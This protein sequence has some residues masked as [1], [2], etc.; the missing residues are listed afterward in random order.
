MKLA[1]AQKDAS[2]RSRRTLSVNR[3]TLRAEVLVCLYGPIEE[4]FLI[5]FGMTAIG[6]DGC[7]VNV[8]LWGAN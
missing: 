8:S 6:V 4:R 7:Y 3:G 2:F 5:S 1:A